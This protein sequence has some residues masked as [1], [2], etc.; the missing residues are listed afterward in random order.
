MKK[1]GTATRRTGTVRCA[2][3]TRKSSEEG[4]EQEFNS[5]QAQREACEAFIDSQRH[6]GWVCQRAAYDDGGFSGATM[7]RPALQQLLADITAG[8]VDTIVVYKIDRLTRSLADFAKIVEI[9]DT[10]GASFVSVTQQFNT[11]TSMGRLTL[12]VLLS[13]AQFERELSSERVRDKIAASR[14]K[15][16]WTG[17]TVPLGYDAKDKKLVINKS[18]AETVRTLFGLY[19]E[20]GSFS[21]VVAELDRRKIVTK[22]RNTKVP[23]YR[24]GISFTY[25]PLAYFLKN[26]IYIGETHYGGKWFKGEHE[27]ILDRSTF[28]R[29]QELL[30]SN[31]VKRRVKFSESGAILQGKLFDDKGNR[32]GPSFSSKNGVRYRFYV[33]TALRGR[34]DTA[35]SVTR[36]PAPEIE[37][38]VEAALSEK[39]QGSQ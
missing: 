12:N 14:R 19:L 18:E 30:K 8:R 39:F 38:L 13:F 10:R 34:K 6:E 32:M 21:K 20:L 22:R 28:D 26:R 24:G 15:G 2:I 33:S 1:P 35:G 29:V 4:L 17:G 7:D 37:G 3:Y 9:L 5:L 36:I 27:A 31:T 23:K 11:T 16:K 25:G